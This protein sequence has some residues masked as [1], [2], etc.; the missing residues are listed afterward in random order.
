MNISTMAN[1]AP[2]TPRSAAQLGLHPTLQREV[3]VKTMFRRSLDGVSDIAD[4]LAVSVPIAQELIDRARELNLIETLGSSRL[5]FQS[6][7][8]QNMLSANDDRCFNELFGKI[9][10]FN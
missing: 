10:A 8:K 9:I 6:A 7:S 1:L 2:E 3:L 5:I 4:S